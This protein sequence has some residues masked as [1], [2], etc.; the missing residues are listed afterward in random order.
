MGGAMKEKKNPFSLPAI[1]EQPAALPAQVT[2][3]EK[4]AR[5]EFIAVSKVVERNKFGFSTEDAIQ[6]DLFEEI[7]KQLE[8]LKFTAGEDRLQAFSG[9]IGL[10]LSEPQRRAL[11]AI[12][13]I[14][15]DRK[16]KGIEDPAHEEEINET[17][18]FQAYGLE[19]KDFNGRTEYTG[20]DKDTARKAL[21]GICITPMALYDRS[22]TGKNTFKEEISVGTLGWLTSGRE[23]L[24]ENG[25][26]I[27][28]RRYFK[29]RFHAYLGR[30]IIDKTGQ[31][32]LQK[33]GAG[34]KVI[35]KPRDI[36]KDIDSLMEKNPA[37]FERDSGG[38]GRTDKAL[39]LP[40]HFLE[41]LFLIHG[42]KAAQKRK[43]IDRLK[44]ETLA[45]H[46]RISDITISRNRK[47]AKEL[48]LNCLKLAE[49]LGFIQKWAFDGAFFDYTLN[50]EKFYSP[51]K[52]A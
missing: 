27:E 25:E 22:R 39:E 10:D 17:D 18:F 30:G 40:I 26:K 7:E 11:N 5:P 31:L 6:T 24:E 19:K 35:Y 45:K 9:N 34:T 33:N 51:Q 20:Y 16:Y 36:R 49:A 2:A 12:Q 15:H 28:K 42:E 43:L 37:L 21:L 4:V 50:E 14:L 23:Y 1:A 3:G 38:I 32:L 41:Y 8:E 44:W 48:L 13:V 52:E 29:L 46:L 47:K